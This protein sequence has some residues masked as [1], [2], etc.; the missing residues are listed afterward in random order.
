[1]AA[2]RRPG[3]CDRG[4][5]HRRAYY[6][7]GRV[8]VL[9]GTLRSNNPHAP[10]GVRVGPVS[11]HRVADHSNLPTLLDGCARL[12]TA[13]KCMHE[14]R[15]QRRAR[16]RAERRRASRA[17]RGRRGARVYPIIDPA[18]ES[19]S[20]ASSTFP[21][22][23]AAPLRTAEGLEALSEHVGGELSDFSADG[24]Y[25]RLAAE[26]GADGK[27]RIRL[28]KME[29]ASTALA[30]CAAKGFLPEAQYLVIARGADIDAEAP[31]IDVAAASDTDGLKNGEANA[32]TTADG[33]EPSP[34][35]D[36]PSPRAVV[37]TAAAATD[38]ERRP[39]SN[40]ATGE[41]RE[42]T[43]S[44]LELACMGGHKPL[45]AFLLSEGARDSDGRALKAAREGNHS[46]T[47]ALL[48]GPGADDNA[49]GDATVV[50]ARPRA[51]CFNEECPV[52]LVPVDERA[53]E[54]SSPE[55]AAAAGG[56]EPNGSV[57]ATAAADTDGC[58]SEE[59][60]ALADPDAGWSIILPCRHAVHA[61]CLTGWAM[62]ARRRSVG[63]EE[64]VACPVCKQE[65]PVS[66]IV[67]WHAARRD[68]EQVAAAPDATA[69]V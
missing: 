4:R 39:T 46:S 43:K 40:T 15:A 21:S 61:S 30:L 63:G 11:H 13:Q 35:T 28:V 26:G 49:G 19:L 48:A 54:R 2:L 18:G 38:A 56:T 25:A 5:N 66:Y 27:E 9:Q 12:I 33:T 7:R 41:G 64:A 67:L 24:I 17:R 47:A 20:F 45:V 58:A 52:C 16:R 29:N 62:A 36:P 10:Q 31:A 68:T 44:P 32:S 6:H 60:D 42:D 50:E 51:R 53:D 59:G 23:M 8:S 1:M 65:V 69:E 14:R 34:G 37:V 3:G 55:T 57:P 22:G